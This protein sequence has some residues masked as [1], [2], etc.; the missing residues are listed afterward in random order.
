[1]PIKVAVI[2]AG[3]VGFTRGMVRDILCVPEFQDTRFAFT[4]IDQRNLDMV[5]QLCKRDIEPPGC[6]RRSRPPSNRREAFTGANYVLSFV[7]VGGLEGFETDID[8]PLKY[9]VD[10]CVGD[11]LCAGRHHVRASATIP[12][13]SDFCKD[14]ARGGRA[15]L[16]LPQLLQPH[17]D[18][19]LGVQP[20]RRRRARS[21]ACATASRAATGMIAEVLGLPARGGGHHLRGHQPPDLVHPASSTRARS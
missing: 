5:Y 8:I 14:I 2:G 10:Q 16:P 11:T 1:M 12:V 15:G 6:R 20:V 9:G 4:D 7:R 13:C 3:S 21:S 18:E 17:G 19:H